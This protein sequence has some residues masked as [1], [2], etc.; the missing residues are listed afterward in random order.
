MMHLIFTLQPLGLAQRQASAALRVSKTRQKV[1][2]VARRAVRMVQPRQMPIA[3]RFFERRVR[4]R[5]T[6]SSRAG[7]YAGHQEG[8]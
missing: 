6:A 4:H 5:F 1:A 2:R 8:A 3:S 7:R